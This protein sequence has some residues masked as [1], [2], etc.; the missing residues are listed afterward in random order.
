M[1]VESSEIFQFTRGISYIMKPV[2]FRSLLAFVATHIAHL[3]S[4]I[5]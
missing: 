2:G 4:P 5:F 3:R 1:N